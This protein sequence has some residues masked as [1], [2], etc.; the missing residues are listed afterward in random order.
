MKSVFVAAVVILL[1]V[2]SADSQ[3]KSQV[4]QESRVSDGLMREDAGSLLFGWF[5]PERF[6][7]HHSVSFSYTTIGGEGISLG[8]YTNSM[9][10]RF[11]DNLDA[12]ADLSLS[13]SPFNT[14]SKF[15]TARNDLSSIYLSR[16][17]V[18]YR[19]WE[20]VTFLLQ[21]RQLPFYGLSRY[22]SPFYDDWGY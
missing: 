1:A 10:Y 17:Q 16:A 7:M 5:N 18:N 20:N 2:S 6:S 4:A 19:P 15:G 9:M 3:F 12:R 13:Y 11:A 21:Y 8:T 14:L 22:G